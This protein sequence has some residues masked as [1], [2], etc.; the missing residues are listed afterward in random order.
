MRAV[1]C[2]Q[3]DLQKQGPCRSAKNWISTIFSRFSTFIGIQFA[4]FGENSP[5]YKAGIAAK[6]GGFG[7]LRV[8]PVDASK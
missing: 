4:F 2:P 8:D 6:G 5:N 3:S 7:G 1:R